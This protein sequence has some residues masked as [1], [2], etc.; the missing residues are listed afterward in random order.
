MTTPVLYSGSLKSN[1]IAGLSGWT[2]S[3][4]SLAELSQICLDQIRD[5]CDNH[6]KRQ[7]MVVNVEQSPIA[8]EVKC[9]WLRM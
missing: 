2:L 6:E 9:V 1:L 3:E 5:Y 7:H 4:K 8:G